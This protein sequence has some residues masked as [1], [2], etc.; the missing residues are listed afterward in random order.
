MLTPNQQ[1]ISAASRKTHGSAGIFH[2]NL[3]LTGDPAVECRSGASGHTLFLTFMNDLT[4]GS[5]SVTEGAATIAGNPTYTGKTMTVN[6]SGVDD[7]QTIAVALN[8]VTD[9]FGQTLPTTSVRMRLLLGDTTGNNV[10]NASD[11]GQTKANVGALVDQATFR[12]D[13]TVNGSINSSDIGT[14]KAAS[15]GGALPSRNGKPL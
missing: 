13:V 15:G 5:A 9:S 14:V 3:S 7:A 6:L 1:L 2:V 10:V 11:V 12:T 4:G 8:N